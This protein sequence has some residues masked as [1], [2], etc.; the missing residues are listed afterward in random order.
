MSNKK[1]TLTLKI[2]DSIIID[3][4]QFL[5]REIDHY[6][7]YPYYIG[8]NKWVHVHAIHLCCDNFGCDQYEYNNKHNR[9]CGLR[10][11]KWCED[12]KWRGIFIDKPVEVWG[13]MMDKGIHY[14]EPLKEIQD[15]I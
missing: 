15:E 14:V 7:D 12:I 11:T 4:D 6:S 8:D 1:Q 10:F 2:G 13:D 3:N 5:I 9:N